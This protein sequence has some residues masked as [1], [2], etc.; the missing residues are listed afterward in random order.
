MYQILKKRLSRITDKYLIQREC[1][2]NGM[3]TLGKIQKGSEFVS[4][5]L[6]KYLDELKETENIYLNDNHIKDTSKSHELVNKE[7]RRFT[8]DSL[9]KEMS[10][11]YISKPK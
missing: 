6:S 8:R 4:K 5:N 7:I 10:V 3:S 2:L 9:L 1:E 11:Y